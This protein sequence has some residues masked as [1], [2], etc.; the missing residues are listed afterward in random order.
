MLDSRAVR[1]ALAGA[2]AL[3]ATACSSTRELMIKSDPPQAAA[4]YV[5]GESVGSTPRK[6]VVSFDPYTRVWIQVVNHETFRLWENT[7]DKDTWPE[8]D[9]VVVSLGGAR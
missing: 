8:E 3:L 7:Y 6:V 5:N 9:E 4:I 1:L 2:L